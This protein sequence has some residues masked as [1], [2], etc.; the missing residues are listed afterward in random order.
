MSTLSVATIVVS[1]GQAD[2]LA[3]TL[4]ALSEQT[5]PSEQ[6]VVVETSSNQDC[7]DLAKSHQFSIVEPGD[8]RLGAAI[9]AGIQSL[10]SQPGWL[11]VL[12]DDSAPRKNRIADAR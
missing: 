5:K 11:W 1:H 8:I 4:Q 7:I 3:A 2:Y 9:E 6:V 10:R 12:H